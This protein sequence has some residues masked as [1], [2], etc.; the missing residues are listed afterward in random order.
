MPPTPAHACL[1]ASLFVCM[2][3][4]GCVFVT[5]YSARICS[6]PH[7]A[8]HTYVYR[9]ELACESARLQQKIYFW[10]VFFCCLLCLLHLFSLFYN[11][12]LVFIKN[13]WLCFI[14]TFV[15]AIL[16]QLQV[17]QIFYLFFFWIFSI[18]LATFFV[19]F[20]TNI[21]VCTYLLSA[22]AQYCQIKYYFCFCISPNASCILHAKYFKLVTFSV[23]FL[24][25]LFC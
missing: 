7:T 3:V 16:L 15:A 22:V 18:F 5:F 13:C 10:F 20:C 21:Y 12:Y 11:F 6:Q 19:C 23:C 25:F 14:S 9:V 24:Q 1:F 8:I 17:L 4:C 2:Y